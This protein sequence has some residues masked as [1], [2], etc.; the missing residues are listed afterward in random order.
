M[1]PDGGEQSVNRKWQVYSRAQSSSRQLKILCVVIAW[2]WKLSVQEPNTGE[3]RFLFLTSVIRPLHWRIMLQPFWEPPNKE[4]H[5]KLKI[6]SIG[7]RTRQIINSIH[8]EYNIH[9]KWYYK[10]NVQA[11]KP[12]GTE[13]A[14]DRSGIRYAGVNWI[15]PQLPAVS[16][17]P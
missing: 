2:K 13:C 11:V 7:I 16:T 5:I 10:R 17:F 9:K 6:I 12:S 15:R 4:E 14:R 8:L 3:L 1:C